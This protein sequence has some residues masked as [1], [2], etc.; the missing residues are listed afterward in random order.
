MNCFLPNNN[1]T[2]NLNFYS[3]SD[4]HYNK[5]KAD[6]D[7]GS[8]KLESDA[9]YVTTTD[10]NM[11]ENANLYFGNYKIT[12][13]VSLNEIL[14]DSDIEEYKNI[15]PNLNGSNIPKNFGVANK[16]YY[17]VDTSK[18]GYTL[19]LYYYNTELNSFVGLN[20]KGGESTGG[21][22]GSSDITYQDEKVRIGIGQS[23][24]VYVPRISSTATP[25]NNDSLAYDEVSKTYIPKKSSAEVTIVTTEQYEQ[26]KTDKAIN[27]TTVYYVRT[28]NNKVNAYLGE[29]EIT[30]STSLSVVPEV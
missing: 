4:E 24:I 13:F 16:L 11:A 10:D 22:S 30:S 21:G 6:T 18:L 28:A 17:W 15:V 7:T 23:D 12:D 26:L 9:F 5:I 25:N 14:L 3:L 29:I 8:H 20:A 1:G 19:Q 27:D 2:K